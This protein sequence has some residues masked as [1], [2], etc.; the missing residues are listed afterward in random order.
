MRH[1]EPGWRSHELFEKERWSN[2]RFK[3][4]TLSQ[5]VTEQL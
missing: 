5:L 2:D 3:R 1:L 4:A